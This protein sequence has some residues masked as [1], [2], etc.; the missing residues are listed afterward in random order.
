MTDQSQLNFNHELIDQGLLV[1]LQG[2]IEFSKSPSLRT[3]LLGLLEKHQPKTFIIELSAV[4]YM[5]SSGIAIIVEIL[6]WQ[7]QRNNKLI[8]AGLQSKV[9]SMLEITR[10]DQLFTVVDDLD[11]AKKQL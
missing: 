8:L 7:R 9:L 3:Q 4:P 2:D 10:L 6:Q 11:A 5:D 1:H